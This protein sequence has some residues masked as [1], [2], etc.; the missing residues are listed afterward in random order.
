MG[1]L[2][3]ASVVCSTSHDPR[4]EQ[5]VMLTIGKIFLRRPLRLSKSMS[6][7]SFFFLISRK[8]FN[9]FFEEQI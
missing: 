5:A 9:L 6:S 1:S 3:K 4:Q 2:G 7:S 8:K